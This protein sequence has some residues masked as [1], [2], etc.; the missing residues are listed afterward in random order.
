[1]YDFG[2]GVC[3]DAIDEVAGD[4]AVQSYNRRSCE[5]AKNANQTNFIPY[6]K[7]PINLRGRNTS[8][9]VENS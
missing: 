8:Y 5:Y 3:K 1:L 6:I 9:K 7:G 2:I 4:F